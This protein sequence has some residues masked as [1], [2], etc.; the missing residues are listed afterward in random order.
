MKKLLIFL[1]LFLLSGCDLRAPVSSNG[2]IT[3]HFS[4]SVPYT[5][6]QL[7]SVRQEIK[8]TIDTNYARLGSCEVYFIPRT[9]LLAQWSESV[10]RNTVA[11]AHWVN[12]TDE[13][14][15]AFDEAR[16]GPQD[17]DKFT[18]IMIHELSH[19]WGVGH[20][21]F[22]FSIMNRTWRPNQKYTA[23]DYELLALAKADGRYGYKE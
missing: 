2:A 12:G 14:G 23:R 22:Q 16:F 20:S 4:D 7:L 15:I 6:E 18:D 11:L 13:C 10:G 1:A 9:E 19:L 21:T 8:D 17:L 3:Y 5:Q